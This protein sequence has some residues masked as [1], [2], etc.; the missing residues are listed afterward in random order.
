MEVTVKI[1]E[2]ASPRRVRAFAGFGYAGNGDHRRQ[3]RL[4]YH[5]PGRYCV[6]RFGRH[7]KSA[8]PR[9][10]ELLQK[11]AFFDMNQIN[12]YILQVQ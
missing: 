9:P 12:R 10:L 1:M 3:R 5:D 11:E 4:C 7:R 2:P 8:H 6:A